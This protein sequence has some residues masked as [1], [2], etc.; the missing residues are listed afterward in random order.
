MKKSTVRLLIGVLIVALLAYFFLYT[1]KERFEDDEEEGFADD[2]DEYEG[3][4]VPNMCQAE[5]R[6]IKGMHNVALCQSNCYLKAINN[7]NRNWKCGTKK[8]GPK[9]K[10][11]QEQVR[12]VFLVLKE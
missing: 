9:C 5:C 10:G 1:R 12:K 11:L 8:A 7:N 4:N 3:F 2:D 6:S